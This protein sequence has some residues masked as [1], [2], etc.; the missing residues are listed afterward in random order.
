MAAGEADIRL[1]GTPNGT[2]DTAGRLLGQTPS[3]TVGPY[4]HLGL[5]RE[6]GNVLAGPEAK[7]EL[8]SI[9]GRVLD[10]NGEPV[11]DAM[12]ELWQAD[13]DGIFPHPAD[14]RN[15]RAHPAF[16][17]FGRVATDGEGRYRFE[18]IKPGAIRLEGEPA[19]APHANLHVFARGVLVHAVTRVY[20][21]GEPENGEDPV[22]TAV[23]E[24]RRETLL[25]SREQAEDGRVAYRFDI[26]LQGDRET[27]FFEP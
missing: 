11:G 10:G 22:L 27:V 21:E 8:I 16:G 19:Q 9:W 1:E 24:E 13:A 26:R 20:F 4:F 7:G 5:I 15:A 25:A 14:P 2:T 18:T 12:L 17:Y 3:Q 6:G 23:P